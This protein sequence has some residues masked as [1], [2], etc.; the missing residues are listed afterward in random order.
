MKNKLLHVTATTAF[1]IMAVCL[2]AFAQNT[3]PVMIE[4]DKNSKRIDLIT[5]IKLQEYKYVQRGSVRFFLRRL[6]KPEKFIHYFHDGSRTAQIIDLRSMEKF[7]KRY[8][9]WRLRFNTGRRDSPQ[10]IPRIHTLAVSFIPLE[11]STKK[12]EKRV[13]VLLDDLKLIDW[14]KNNK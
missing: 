3:S 14:G 12:A 9:M 6:D 1:L 8:A 7:Q 13:Y 2:N 4:F 10:Y 5:G 11:T